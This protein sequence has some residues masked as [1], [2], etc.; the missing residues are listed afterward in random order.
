M[1]W[2]V[3]HGQETWSWKSICVSWLEESF[4]GGIRGFSDHWTLPDPETLGRV[5]DIIP[6][7]PHP[8]PYFSWLLRTFSQDGNKVAL[9]GD[10]PVHCLMPT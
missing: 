3:G 9:S 6:S 4:R 10:M 5:G 7:L 1:V 2:G 8:F